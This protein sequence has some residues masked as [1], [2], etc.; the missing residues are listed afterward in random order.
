MVGI[1]GA[2]YHTNVLSLDSVRGKWT[3]RMASEQRTWQLP[4]W[5]M[6]LLY[7]HNAHMHVSRLIYCFAM[8]DGP[9]DRGHGPSHNK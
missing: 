6:Q 9:D 3:A 2:L 8:C 1:Q 7:L 4:I 5:H